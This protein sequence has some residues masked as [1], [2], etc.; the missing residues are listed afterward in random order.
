M[1]SCRWHTCFSNILVSMDTDII[2]HLR[3]VFFITDSYL[4][5]REKLRKAEDTSDLQT[6]PEVIDNN[7]KPQK[8]KIR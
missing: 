5:A 3:S 4:K 8:R 1:S 6:E 7:V 2:I